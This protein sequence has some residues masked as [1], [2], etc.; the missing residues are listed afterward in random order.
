LVAVDQN[1]ENSI[2]IKEI[3]KLETFIDSAE[4]FGG[5]ESCKRRYGT[6]RKAREVL[7]TGESLPV[8]LGDR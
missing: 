7:L 2:N 6:F 1:I 4:F 5:K 8:G 3:P